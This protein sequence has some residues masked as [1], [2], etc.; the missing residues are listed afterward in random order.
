MKLSEYDSI[1]NFLDSAIEAHTK[2]P[3]RSL[4]IDNEF[5][6]RIASEAVPGL[7][8]EF[9]VATGY[10]LNHIAEKFSDRTVYGFDWFNG[11][12][13]DWRADHR[14]GHFACAAPEV[15]SNAE[16]VVGLFNDTLPKFMAEHPGEAASFIHLDADLYSS[17]VTIFNNIEDRIVKGT[18]LLFDELEYPGDYREHEYKAFKEFLELSNHDVEYFGT[19]GRETVAFRIV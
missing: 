13:E 15:R 12:P 14:K 1:E 2:T 8:M 11:L 18:I 16:L 9:G 4:N 3:H 6:S 5:F 19:R 17:T 10:T 7:V